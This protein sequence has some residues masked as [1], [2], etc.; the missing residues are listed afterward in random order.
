MTESRAKLG[1]VEL[2]YETL[3]EP[4]DPAVV[5]VMGLGGQFHYWPDGFCEDL[6]SRGLFVV[7]FDNRDVGLS[8]HLSPAAPPYGLEAM[9]A[10]VVGLIG[11]LGREAAHL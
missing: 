10:D 2:F 4:T 1:D 5:L 3:G 11:A 8:T 7:R 6:V 9:A